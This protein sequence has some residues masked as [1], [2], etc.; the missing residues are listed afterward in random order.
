[1]L[2]EVTKKKKKVEEDKV[3]IED[4][5]R[6]LTIRL[7]EKT[8]KVHRIASM[9]LETMNQVMIVNHELNG[10]DIKITTLKS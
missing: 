10:K 3:M 5:K 2:C 9:Q 7:E 4:D 1:M 8:S 6:L